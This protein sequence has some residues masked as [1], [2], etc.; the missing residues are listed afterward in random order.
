[1]QE[2]KEIIQETPFNLNEIKSSINMNEVI[3]QN[4]ILFLC[5]DTLRYDIAKKAE[6]EQT[7][8]VLNS[9]GE[10]LECSAAGNFTYP[11]HHSMFV[12]FLPA[13]IH[14]KNIQE[15][16]MLFFPKGIG[17]GKKPKNSFVFEGATIMEGLAKMGYHTL[18]IGGVSFF[19][20]RTDIGRIFPNMFLESH[21]TQRFSCS[22][23]KSAEYQ[24]E[25]VLKCLDEL[26]K[27]D[28]N[29]RIFCYINF[30]AI[31]Y[32]NNYYLENCKK[33]CLESH[34]KALE[35]IDKSLEPLFEAFKK[36]SKT[37]VIA[38]S[39][40]GTCY[41][42]DGYLFHGINHSIVNTVPYKHFFL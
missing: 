28:K 33:D 32:P 37:F 34:Q 20:K 18:C 7:T 13:P 6:K 4:D 23:P 41:G 21:W 26:D 10:W 25:K 31:H 3:S 35:Y 17:M 1:M 14:A 8:P 38:T 15:R 19:N 39:D 30:S 16:E 2:E 11:S 29:K 9:Y 27:I 12:G 5:F 42:E 24:I 22:Q 36:R 40:H